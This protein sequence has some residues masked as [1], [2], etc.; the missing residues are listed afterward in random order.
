MR[1]ASPRVAS[2]APHRNVRQPKT[3]EAIAAELIMD[4]YLY[5]DH[6]LEMKHLDPRWML[7]GYIYFIAALR[8]LGVRPAPV[9]S[10]DR[11]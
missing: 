1:S 7:A 11:D 6:Y 10:R 9:P 2:A 3:V 4:G 8:A 5:N